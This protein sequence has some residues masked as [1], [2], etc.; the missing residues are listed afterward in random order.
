MGNTCSTKVEE[1]EYTLG[2]REKTLKK[3]QQECL[4]VGGSII[5]K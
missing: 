3:K 1:Q 4:D 2:F 5:L